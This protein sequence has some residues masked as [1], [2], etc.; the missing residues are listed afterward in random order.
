MAAV[1]LDVEAVSLTG[2]G[3]SLGR[4]CRSSFF[5]VGR[6]LSS[7]AAALQLE[8]VRTVHHPVDD[9]VADRHVAD[10]FVPAAD[11]NLA[12]D[13]QRALVIP[14]VDDLQQV[15]ALLGR[16]RLGSPIVDDQ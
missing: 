13:Q 7:Q 12:G 10:D 8:A 3:L 11:R 4:L 5:P 14:V 1:V 6:L 15:T 9:G 16:Q 2:S